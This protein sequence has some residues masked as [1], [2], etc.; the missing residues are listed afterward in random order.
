MSSRTFRCIFDYTPANTLENIRAQVML[1]KRKKQCDLAIV[2]YLQVMNMEKQG[3]EN[4]NQ[5]VGYNIQGF[6]QMA[7]DAN[8]LGSCP[9]ANE[10]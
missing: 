1:Q 2:D 4:A 6:K 5:T 9:F 7:Q 3:W 8:I 10:P